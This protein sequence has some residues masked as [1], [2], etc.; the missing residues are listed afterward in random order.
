M[1]CSFSKVTQLDRVIEKT[2]C[3]NNRNNVQQAHSLCCCC[4]VTQSCPTLCDPMDCST[5]PGLPEPHH[6]LKFARVHIHFISDA[7][8]PSDPLMLFSSC[9]QSV[10]ASGSFPMSQLFAQVTEYWSFSISHS[11]EYLGLISFKMD[12]F[13]LLA[14]QEILKSLLQHHS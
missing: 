10:P 8:Q 12:W 2:W 9:P 11:N 7:I 1:F 13:D 3:R 4:S 6:L 14:V 5:P